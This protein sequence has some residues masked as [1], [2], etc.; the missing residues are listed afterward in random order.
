MRGMIKKNCLPVDFSETFAEGVVYHIGEWYGM[1]VLYG[2][3][4]TLELPLDEVDILTYGSA[5]K[6]LINKAP[7]RRAKKARTTNP[8]QL[9]LQLA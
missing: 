2:E 8:N 9:V 1:Y 3:H 6:G 4:G 5:M 7:V